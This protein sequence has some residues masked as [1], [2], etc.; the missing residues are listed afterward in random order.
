MTRTP[1]QDNSQLSQRLKFLK[2]S[3][4]KFL[5]TLTSFLFVAQWAYINFS[6]WLELNFAKYAKKKDCSTLRE[7]DIN[8]ITW[9]NKKL[10]D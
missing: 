7:W 4:Q 1:N 10:D 2:Y 6:V 8:D 5:N 9:A 3:F